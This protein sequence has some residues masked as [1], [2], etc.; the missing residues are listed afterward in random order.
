MMELFA[1]G[2][3]TALRRPRPRSAGGS[4]EVTNLLPASLRLVRCLHLIAFP[5]QIFPIHLTGM[6]MGI[7][8][9]PFAQSGLVG[10]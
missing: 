10:V 3:D 2:R 8:A 5:G 1:V 9:S 4:N 6:L 7:L